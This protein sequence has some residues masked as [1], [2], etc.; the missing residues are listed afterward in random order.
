MENKIKNHKSNLSNKEL[1]IEYFQIN[2]NTLLYNKEININKIIKI[3]NILQVIFLKKLRC[4][5]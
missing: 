5:N 4:L 1:N 2:Q 3:K